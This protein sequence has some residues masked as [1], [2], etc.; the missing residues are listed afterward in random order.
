MDQ[1]A[2]AFNPLR[3]S[4]ASTDLKCVGLRL[5]FRAG[6]ARFD[7]GIG[8]ETDALG[9]AA[10]GTIDLASETLDLLLHPRIMDRSGIDLARIAGA[11]RVQGPL[12]APRV[13]FNPVG[14]ITVAGDIAALAR[15]GRAALLGAL[16]PTA[17][18]G[19]S[20]CAVALGTARADAAPARAA[21]SP[22]R[23]PPNDPARDLNR[24]LG[25]LLGR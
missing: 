5:P 6:V 21:E 10:S 12:D 16:A 18:S 15:G 20:E 25:K 19:P 22:S 14:T 7:R 3:T 23:V 13:A 17:P 9:V 1:L 4:G 24:A 8:L 2:S 11:V